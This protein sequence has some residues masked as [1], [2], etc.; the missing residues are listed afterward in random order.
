VK[1]VVIVR[2]SEDDTPVGADA[3]LPSL[4]DRV[5]EVRDGNGRD[6]ADDGDDDQQLDQREPVRRTSWRARDAILQAAPGPAR[7]N[8]T[9]CRARYNAARPWRGA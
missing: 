5:H 3:P 8:M 1:G 7:R 6:Q 2:A 9:R 4:V